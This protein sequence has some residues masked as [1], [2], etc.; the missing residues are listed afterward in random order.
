MD[1]KETVKEIDVDGKKYYLAFNMNSMADIEAKY[2]TIGKWG[3]LVDSSRPEKVSLTALRYGLMCM[4]NEGIDI[5]NEKNGTNEPF[6]T[7]RQA[8]RIVFSMTTQK[9]AEQMN[10]LIV[11]SVKTEPKNT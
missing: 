5:M 1:W 3:G 7:E 11:E 9:A 10:E 4:L 8:G 6:L 2:G